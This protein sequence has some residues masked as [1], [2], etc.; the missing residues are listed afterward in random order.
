MRERWF[1]AQGAQRRGPF[2]LEEVVTAVRA[3]P[4]PRA[5]LVWRKGLR[6]W[7]L[8]EAVTEIERRLEQSRS[9]EGAPPLA[10]RAESVPPTR[11]GTTALRLL[12]GL[13][14]IV[15]VAAVALVVLRQRSAESLVRARPS[16]VSSLPTPAVSAASPA[17]PAPL[18]SP[19]ARRAPMA[20]PSAAEPSPVPGAAA[21]ARSAPSLAEDESDL[22]AAE[23]RRLRGVAAWSGDTLRLTV[24]NATAWRLTAIQVRI[25]RLSGEDF[26]ADERPLILLPPAHR[27]DARVADLLERV[28]PDRKKPGV[29]ALD[30]GVFEGSAGPVPEAFRWEFVSARG[31]PPSR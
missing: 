16:A 6:D 25:E 7:T 30:T 11:K 23:L 9:P 21:P 12:A 2:S 1:F 28:A 4:D 14:V 17:A 31:Y 26:V 22:P 15:A 5:V 18:R 13:A 24:Y 10:D 3:E 8:A 27:V 19:G 20:L 29:N